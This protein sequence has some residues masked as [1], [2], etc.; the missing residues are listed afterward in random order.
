MAC[1]ERNP[2]GYLSDHRNSTDGAL[3]N[4][5]LTIKEPKKGRWAEDCSL[6]TTSEWRARTSVEPPD[7][8]FELV[9]SVVAIIHENST[10]SML[11]K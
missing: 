9:D 4:Y 5:V 8:L 6:C 1:H 7:L 3:C 11:V 2:R 10:C